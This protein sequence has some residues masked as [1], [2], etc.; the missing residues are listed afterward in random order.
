M[1]IL[2]VKASAGP[3]LGDKV[4]YF[5]Y[6]SNVSAKTFAKR[7]VGTAQWAI[8]RITNPD[9][10][11]VFGHRAG[12]ATLAGGKDVERADSRMPQW[13]W[14]LSDWQH[15][16]PKEEAG[17]SLVYWQPYGVLYA[18]TPEQLEIIRQKE[19]GYYKT[20][21]EVSLQLVDENSETLDGIPSELSTKSL[22]NTP[23]SRT[24]T[25][26]GKINRMREPFSQ[27]DHAV[28]AVVFISSPWVTLRHPVAPT[29]RYRDLILE[30]GKDKRLPQEYLDWLR[31]MPTVPTAALSEPQYEDTPVNA[32]TK[33][34]GSALLVAATI[35]TIKGF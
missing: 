28:N 9:I 3:E 20:T 35:A 5:A 31:Q 19:I 7:G 15:L 27:L 34:I 11:L 2:R 13:R 6:G 12:Y 24:P 25:E 1:T 17:T 22:T 10:A 32:A 18:L 8:A 23:I 26:G 33:L 16:P 14:S 4:L 30:G 29:Q 21:M